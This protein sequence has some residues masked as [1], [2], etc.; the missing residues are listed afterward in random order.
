MAEPGSMVPRGKP[1]PVSSPTRDTH[2]AGCWVNPNA[3]QSSG[4]R[5]F[6]PQVGSGIRKEAITEP[7]ARYFS[8]HETEEYKA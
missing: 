2:P 3:G 7:I 4:V 6:Y 8:P 5:N 1:A